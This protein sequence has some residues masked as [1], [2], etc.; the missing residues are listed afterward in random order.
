[1]NFI[2]Q[3]LF[4]IRFKHHKPRK[5]NYFPVFLSF[6]KR[7]II[8]IW[9]IWNYAVTL[10]YTHHNIFTLIFF[11]PITLDIHQAKKYFIQWRKRLSLSNKNLL[12][13][14]TS[15]LDNHSIPWSS[16]Y[17]NNNIRKQKPHTQSFWSCRDQGDGVIFYLFFRFQV[18]MKVNKKREVRLFYP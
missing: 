11:P 6:L 2:P 12:P 3:P 14:A 18:T 9:F 7:R 1:M 4:S 10:F 16:F 5:I 15:S 17:K 13:W 8:Y